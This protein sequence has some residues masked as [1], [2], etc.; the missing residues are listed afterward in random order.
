MEK[1]G[2]IN[3]RYSKVEISYLYYKDD[4]KMIWLLNI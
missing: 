2:I 1:N 4:R 3:Y